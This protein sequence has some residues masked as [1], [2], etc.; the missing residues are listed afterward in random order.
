[1][2]FTIYTIPLWIVAVVGTALAALTGYNHD[3]KGAYS[4]FALFVGAVLWAGG[5]AME[6]SSS[7]G[8]AAIFWYKIHFI[9]SAIVPTAILIMALRFTGRDGLINRRNVAALAV[10]PVVTTLLILTSHD[11]WIQGHLANTGADAVL[12]LTYQFGPWFP[13][14]AY[15]S[16]AIALAAI[17]MFGEAVLER[18]DE[19]LLNTSTAF[20]VATILPTVGTA[21][22]VIGGTQIDYGPFGFLISGL[23]IMA[24]MFYL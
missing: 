13:I 9:G 18:L 22:Y 8:Q 24:A 7:P 20:L 11:I 3:Q 21:I 1:M 16:L 17:A 19:G 14:Y 4:L 12:P 10:V 23:C 5:Y 15:Y 2:E 6:M